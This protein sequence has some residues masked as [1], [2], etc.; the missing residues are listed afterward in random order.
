MS[1]QQSLFAAD[2]RQ[3]LAWLAKER[4]N[5]QEQLEWREQIPGLL[6]GMKN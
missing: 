5:V 2:L 4:R 6:D 3:V 1:T